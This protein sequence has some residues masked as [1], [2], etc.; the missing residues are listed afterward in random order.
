M[1][2][3]GSGTITDPEFHRRRAVHATKSRTSLDHYVRQ[4]VARAPDLTE[5]QLSRL[6]ALLRTGGRDNA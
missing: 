6:A 3:T 4:V 1:P 5:D 2:S